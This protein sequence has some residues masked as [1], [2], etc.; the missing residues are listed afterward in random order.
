MNGLEQVDHKA[1]GHGLAVDVLRP[2][3]QKYA[4]WKCDGQ[5]EQV[6][7]PSWFIV[8]SRRCDASA[9]VQSI[10]LCKQGWR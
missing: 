9:L 2:A 8:P 10:R 4:T 1:V 7:T 5:I 6:Y 3:V